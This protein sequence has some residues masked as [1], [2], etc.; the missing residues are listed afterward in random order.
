MMPPFLFETDEIKEHPPPAIEGPRWPPHLPSEPYKRVLLPSEN[1]PS[2]LV[3]LLPSSITPTPSL[4]RA[5][6]PPPLRHHR[7]SS[8]RP[9]IIGAPPSPFP[10]SHGKPPCT[11]AAAR[12]CSSEPWPSTTVEPRP[13]VS[14]WSTVLWTES[15]RFLIQK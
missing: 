8:E 7:S 12:R 1:H 11:R 10:L 6:A 14:T 9:L 3:H 5:D 2:L 4:L 15:I 13:A